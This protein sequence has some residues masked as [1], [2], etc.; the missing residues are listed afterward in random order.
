M[1]HTSNGGKY[2]SFY[3]SEMVLN[4]NEPIWI[5][6]VPIDDAERVN[7]DNYRTVNQLR[8]SNPDATIHFSGPFI[9]ATQELQWSCDKTILEVKHRPFDRTQFRDTDLMKRMLKEDFFRHQSRNRYFAPRTLSIPFE[10]KKEIKITPSAKGSKWTF[11]Y[12]PKD[13]FYW[14]MT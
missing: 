3:F 13:P 9:G 11:R 10:R 7:S 8:E 4:W 6:R 12:C 2:M 5:Y 14:A 1:I